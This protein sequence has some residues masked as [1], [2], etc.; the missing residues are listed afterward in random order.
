MTFGYRHFKYGCAISKFGYTY[1]YIKF[2]IQTFQIWV[3]RHVKACLNQFHVTQIDYGIHYWSAEY[4][5][6]FNS[7]VVLSQVAHA[8]AIQSTGVLLVPVCAYG[9]RI[10]KHWTEQSSSDFSMGARAVKTAEWV[11]SFM[12]VW[13]LYGL[14][15]YENRPVSEP[16]VLC[17]HLWTL[18]VM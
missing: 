14:C 12:M 11:P 17:V 8:S 3:L 16:L 7:C 4:T 2:W 10:L 1:V 13:S 6:Q 15:G 18:Q 5:S 9:E